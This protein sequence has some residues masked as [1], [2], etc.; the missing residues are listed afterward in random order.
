MNQ[1][2]QTPDKPDETLAQI[3][4][5]VLIRHFSA[6]KAETGEEKT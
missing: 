1:N 3:L 6:D 5:N 2:D 4:V